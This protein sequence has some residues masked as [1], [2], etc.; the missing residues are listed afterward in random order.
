M[1]W[2]ENGVRPTYTFNTAKLGWL[3]APDI[4]SRFADLV[5]ANGDRLPSREQLQP[6]GLDWIIGPTM[7]GQP[8]PAPASN[9]STMVTVTEAVTRYLVALK[10]K[11]NAP[12]KRTTDEYDAYLRLHI[13]CRALG[14]MDVATVE[15]DDI[16]AWQ[17]ELSST[18]G[19]YGRKV[20]GRNSVLKVRSSLLAPAM[21]W[22]CSKRSGPLRTQPNPLLDSEAPRKVDAPRRDLLHT[23]ADY[24]TFLRCAY[25]VDSDWA[26]ML[27]VA[28]VTGLRRGELIQLGPAAVDATR[29]VLYVAERYSAGLVEPGR[30]NSEAGE[31][32][33]P[34]W[35]T[36]RILAPRRHARRPLLFTGPNGNRWAW[37]TEADRW[38][39]LR[40]AL[41]AANLHRYLTPHCLRHGYNT[42][43]TSHQIH[44][45]KISIVMGHK[46]NKI[47][48]R[49]TQLTEADLAMIR[50]AVTTLVPATA[51]PGA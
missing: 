34:R 6:F 49:Y 32:P 48:R 9:G 17:L 35:V 27:A 1:R 16:D 29:D 18:V 47:G 44:P 38:T 33:V 12:T 28:A 21:T 14:A 22:A 3:E 36:E 43:L 8:L 20:L 46:S 23:P 24:L 51:W 31:V 37:T 7:T 41:A 50:D 39:A 4:A 11:L 15:Y 5:T 10:A 25:A 26:A 30:K 19:P 40:T 45:E 2:R 13:Q 42:W